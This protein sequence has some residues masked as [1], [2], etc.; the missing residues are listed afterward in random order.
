MCNGSSSATTSMLQFE[1][2]TPLY[3][4][5]EL[6]GEIGYK[7]RFNLGSTSTDRVIK[8]KKNDLLRQI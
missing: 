4:L 1:I 5:I 6:I 2:D 8:A 3:K 7:K